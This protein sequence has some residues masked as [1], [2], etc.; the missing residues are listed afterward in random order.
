MAQAGRQRGGAGAAGSVP[1]RV[2]AATCDNRTLPTTAGDVATERLTSALRGRPRASAVVA[3][4][5][6]CRHH[7]NSSNDVTMMIEN[8]DNN[9]KNV[10][11]K[12]ADNHRSYTSLL[13]L[14]H[15]ILI[16]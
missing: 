9:E 4:L 14:V 12:D 1:G 5:K 7:S 10:D 8:D 13:L 15:H 11:E 3:P 2:A 16:N 6:D